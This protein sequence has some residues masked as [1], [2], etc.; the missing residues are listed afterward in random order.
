MAQILP[1][2][3]MV[4]TSP[5]VVRVH[6]AL[7]QL[8]DDN[9]VVWHRLHIHA[10]P[11]PD[12]WLL[13]QG[14]HAL[15]IKV[16][17]L[18]LAGAQRFGQAD[19]FGTAAGRPAEAEH[20]AMLAFA[21]AQEA[22]ARDLLGRMPGWILFPN[23][24]RPDLRLL[25]SHAEVPPGITWVG[26]EELVGSALR[27]RL[28]GGLSLPLSPEQVTWMRCLFTPEVIIPAAFTVRKPVERHTAAQATLQLMDYDQEAVL[29]TDLELSAEG[30]A[31]AGDFGLRLINGV[32]GS[33]KSL[34][35]V[36]RAKLL[37]QLYPEKKILGL[38]H[39]R[40]LIRDL[41]ARYRALPPQTPAV[42]WRTFNQWCKKLWPDKATWRDPVALSSR[43]RIVL[44]IWQAHLGDTAVSERMLLEEI[45]WIKDRLIFSVS[46][47]LRAERI[48]RGFAL[49]EVQRKRVYAAYR[50]YQ[51]E[52]K[53]C[54]RADWGD[55]PRMIWSWL[56]AG[57]IRLPQYDAIL[58]DEA[59]FFAPIWFELIK[60]AVRPGTGHLFLVADPT[61][62]FLRRRQSW[63]ASGLEVRGKVHQLKKSYRTTR[64]IL[65]FA[66]LLYRT[67]LG[68]DDDEEI[69]APDLMDMPHGT[70]PTIIVLTSG[71]DEITRVVNE[72]ERLVAQG[73]PRRDVLVIHADWKGVD[74]V[75]ERLGKKLGLGAVVDPK[76]QDP[77]DAVR[78]CTLNAATG[79]E[80]P[81]VFLAGVRSLFEQEQSVRL[82][83][84]ERAELVRDN[85]RKLYMAITRA[86]QRLML[87]YVGELPEALRKLRTDGSAN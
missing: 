10:E 5:E 39:N 56:Q 41:Q 52:L 8:P 75:I 63:V 68:E 48:G 76:K 7:K 31:A 72:V 83:E 73:L 54:E 22:E 14:R 51:D 82:S 57:R 40:P 70:V 44:Q 74:R 3:P 79:L 50:A 19:L 18:S 11:G 27:A 81:I 80:S 24:T 4:K 53:A 34:I 42:E 64:E 17:G 69:V 1:E 62:G 30:R 49:S 77:S 84:E 85:T 33:G 38:T 71:Q 66:T 12:F 46:D 6:R 28:L 45:D 65:D 15:L 26:K 61:Q 86:G 9:F 29:K 78:V 16:S 55:I 37:R 43:E 25:A 47:Y 87:T 58:V 2:V 36:Y 13:Y 32:A 60:R 59:Q 20:R 35:V 21:Q 23:L 67:R